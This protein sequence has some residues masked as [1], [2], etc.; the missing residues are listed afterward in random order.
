MKR[1]GKN[2]QAEAA[3]V[4]SRNKPTQELM[5]K[6]NIYVLLSV[7]YQKQSHGHCAEQV[8]WGW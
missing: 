7:L 5:K 3:N 4:H 1:E 2:Q 8:Q 6:G